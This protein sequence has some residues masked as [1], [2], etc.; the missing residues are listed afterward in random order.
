LKPF[1]DVLSSTTVSYCPNPIFP[2]GLIG[3]SGFFGSGVFNIS[4]AFVLM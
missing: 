4:S 1:S 2:L 3:V